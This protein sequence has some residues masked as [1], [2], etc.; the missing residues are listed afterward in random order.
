MTGEMNISKISK[1]LVGAVEIDPLEVLILHPS[2]KTYLNPDKEEEDLF[3]EKD[4]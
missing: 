3:H 4:G 2:L 1:D